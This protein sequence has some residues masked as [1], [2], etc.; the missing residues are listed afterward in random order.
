MGALRGIPNVTVQETHDGPGEIRGKK[1]DAAVSL[2]A[3]V[4]ARLASGGKF[5][6]GILYDSTR[7]LSGATRDSVWAVVRKFADGVARTVL[8]SKGLIPDLASPGQLDRQDVATES[9]QAGFALAIWL[10]YFLT[11]GVLNGLVTVAIDT[12]AGE[13]D[14]N[15]LETV[16]VTSASRQDILLGKLLAVVSAGL[17]ATLASCAGMSAAILSGVMT[18]GMSTCAPAI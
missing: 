12:T 1:L 11:I 2:P 8:E 14:R 5:K 18:S 10:P 16:L 13:K 7:K 17:V 4:E 9:R 15:T 3:D 6:V